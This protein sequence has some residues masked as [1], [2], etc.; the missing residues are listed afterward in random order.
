MEGWTCIGCFFAAP[1]G[2]LFIGQAF[3]IVE[4]FCH[5]L[6]TGASIRSAWHQANSWEG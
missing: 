5:A 1:L 2:L 4:R 3:A 6:K